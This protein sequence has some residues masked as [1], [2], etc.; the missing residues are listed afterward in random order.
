MTRRAKFGEVN[1]T[2]DG[3]ELKVGDKAPEFKAINKDLSDYISSEDDGK[4]K[5]ISVV[6]SIDTSVC[7][8]QTSIFT[9]AA[10][11]FSD[12]VVLITISNDLPFAQI[13]FCNVKD[14]EKNKFVSDYIYNDF[15]KKY[16]TIMN[17]LQLLN[18][19]VFVIDKDNTIHYVQYLSQNS[20]LPDTQKAIEAVKELD[21]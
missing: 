10:K 8:I 2:L 11:E 12:N 6:P 4:I 20:E 7:E 17:E 1:I 14:I 3:E 18:R 13:R 15:G 21:K 5:L 19:S 16:N 9:K